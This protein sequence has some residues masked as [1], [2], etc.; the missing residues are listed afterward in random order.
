MEYYRYFNKNKNLLKDK[1]NNQEIVIDG[2]KYINEII[3][4]DK[5]LTK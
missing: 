4:D 5:T 1:S 3:F 2:F